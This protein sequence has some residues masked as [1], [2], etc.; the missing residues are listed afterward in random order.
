MV[1]QMWWIAA[2]VIGCKMHVMLDQY[3]SS[4]DLKMFTLSAVTTHSGKS[5]CS[6]RQ[7]E[8]SNGH[9]IVCLLLF[10]FLATSHANFDDQIGR[11]PVSLAGSNPWS[12]QTNDL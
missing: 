8:W 10:Y 7:I 2:T 6:A 3:V 12:S 5:L 4:R 1:P 11:A 9:W